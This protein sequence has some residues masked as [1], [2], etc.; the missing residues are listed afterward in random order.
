MYRRLGDVTQ[1]TL[2]AITLTT[3]YG[4]EGSNGEWDDIRD[5]RAA[6]FVTDTEG[7][8]FVRPPP[9]HGRV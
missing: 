2:S 3:A 1:D 7:T 5:F 8:G 6:D 9:R 4:S